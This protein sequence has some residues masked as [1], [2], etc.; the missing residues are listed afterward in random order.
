MFPRAAAT[1]DGRP[2][3]AA[4]DRISWEENLATGDLRLGE[5][6]VQPGGGKNGLRGEGRI[7][8][9]ELNWNLREKFEAEGWKRSRLEAGRRCGRC[10]GLGRRC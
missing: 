4:G 3:D 5:G 2:P 6:G 7:E 9:L 10:R 8:R 1:G